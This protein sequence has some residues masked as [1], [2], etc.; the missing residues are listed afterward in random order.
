MGA[1]KNDIIRSRYIGISSLL[2]FLFQ[3]PSCL[4]AANATIIP[5]PSLSTPGDRSWKNELESSCKK[6]KRP[7]VRQSYSV[8]PCG[9]KFVLWTFFGGWGWVEK[10][11]NPRFSLIESVSFTDENYPQKTGRRPV[12]L[13][14]FF[15]C[16]KFWSGPLDLLGLVLAH[17]T[18]RI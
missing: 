8:W 17:K 14:I 2:T 18:F 13:F 11:S 15:F 5:V 6:R 3:A 16:V 12:F 10:K 9:L 7:T 1:L 4:A